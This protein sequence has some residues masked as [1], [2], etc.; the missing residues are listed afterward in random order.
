MPGAEKITHSFVEQI[1][2]KNFVYFWLCWV[3]VAACQLSLAAFSFFVVVRGLL[4]VVASLV[5]EH[6]HVDSVVVAPG[7]SC[8]VARGIIPD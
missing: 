8:H 3:L 7:L 6:R 1:T 5:A 2:F 4:M